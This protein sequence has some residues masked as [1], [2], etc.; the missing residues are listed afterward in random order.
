MP[1]E[2]DYEHERDREKDRKLFIGGLSYETT[3][4]SMKTH[5]EQWG[6]IVDCVVMRDMATK[7]SRG[8][9]FITYKKASQLDEAQQN[10]P[11]IIDGKEVEPKRAV[12]REESSKPEAQM[13]VKKIFVGGIR[14]D[15]EESHLK[16]YFMQYGN[17][18][19]VDIITEKGTNRKRGFAFVSFDDYDPVD[20]IVLQRHH[21]I[22]GHHSEVKKAVSKQE[23]A[24]AMDRG[25]SRGSGRGGGRFG[26]RGDG[27]NWGGGGGGYGG[28]GGGY[29]GGG[30]GGGG[31][32]N[33]GG[34]YG[35]QG[36][37]NFGGGGYG[38]QGAGNFGGGYSNQ[39]GY[40]GGMGG[41]MGGGNFGGGGGGGGG[42]FGANGGGAGWNQNQGAGGNWGNNSGGGLSNDYGSG[43]YGG[44]AMKGGSYSQ[45]GSGPYNSGYGGG[46]N[47]GGGGSS[48]GGGN[49]GGG[50]GGGYSRR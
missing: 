24:S 44:G 46:G 3:E 15:T 17:V 4:D 6:E 38:N 9:G 19:S 11:H 35:N 7:R 16:D 45:R 36:G 22:N 42:N 49:Y 30:G 31:Y 40:G 10:R 39:G 2:R 21:T 43:G 34:G 26:N 32:G 50:G 23:M 25:A 48:S 33:Q 29:G 1:A 14:D 27:D 47:S 12:P 28:G 20:K 37:G 13:T 41:N 18:T 5:F 8:F